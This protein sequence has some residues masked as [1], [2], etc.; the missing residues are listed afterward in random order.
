ME[1][2]VPDKMCV[3]GETAYNPSLKH[4]VL[5]CRRAELV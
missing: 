1:A 3:A 5:Y 2:E 4:E